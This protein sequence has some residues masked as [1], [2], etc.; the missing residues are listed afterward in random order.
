MRFPQR[1][2]GNRGLGVREYTSWLGTPSFTLQN[3]VWVPKHPCRQL[4]SISLWEWA[5]AKHI[6]SHG[7]KMWSPVTFASGS[8]LW[9]L[10]KRKRSKSVGATEK[11]QPQGSLAWQCF[12]TTPRMVRSLLRTWWFGVK[13]RPAAAL[14]LYHLGCLALWD[15]DAAILPLE[16]LRTN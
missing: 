11:N 14:L 4:L 12:V 9:S 7:S 10:L 16:H 13:S 8:F 15:P 3:R 5:P 2:L 1:F 6:C